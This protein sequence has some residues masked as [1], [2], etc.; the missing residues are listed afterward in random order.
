MRDLSGHQGTLSATVRLINYLLSSAG[1]E[2][3]AMQKIEP[4]ARRKIVIECG[5]ML[6]LWV[7]FICASCRY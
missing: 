6:V 4:K 7:R 2:V 1:P 5:N 3:L